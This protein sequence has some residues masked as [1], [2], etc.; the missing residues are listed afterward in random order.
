MSRVGDR[1]IDRVWNEV[2]RIGALENWCFLAALGQVYLLLKCCRGLWGHGF[3]LTLIYVRLVFL[4]WQCRIIF[5]LSPADS[6]RTQIVARYQL[7]LMGLLSRNTFCM[8]LGRISLGDCLC[9]YLLALVARVFLMR[10]SDR[11][12][13]W[14]G[15]GGCRCFGARTQSRWSSYSVLRGPLLLDSGIV[16]VVLVGSCVTVWHMVW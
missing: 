15:S 13:V 14:G 2:L 7:I 6:Q 9:L 1:L 4:R 10:Q 11:W 16:C 8:G 12:S 5:D 3:Q